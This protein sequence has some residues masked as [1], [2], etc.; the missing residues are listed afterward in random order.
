MWTCPDCKREFKSTSQV[1][2]CKDYGL[3]VHFRNK[4]PG[5]RES[6]DALVKAT[7]SFGSVKLHSSKTTLSLSGKSSFVS[8]S[9][10]KKYLKI[11][12]ALNRIRDEFPVVRTRVFSKNKIAHVVYLDGSEQVDAQLMSL[13]KEA[14]TLS[15]G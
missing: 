14:W 13:L 4:M 15:Q 3:E 12:F 2:T 1:H 6:F 10:E 11:V 7:A 8:I 5:V 9:T